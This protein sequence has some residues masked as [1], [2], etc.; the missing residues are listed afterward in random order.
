MVNMFNMGKYNNVRLAHNTYIPTH[1]NIRQPQPRLGL[2][3][4]GGGNHSH[5]HTHCGPQN[6]TIN[7]GPQGFWGF[8]TGLCQGLFGGFFGGGMFGGFGMGNMYGMGM[9]GMYGGSLFN[10]L[11]CLSL[12]NTVSMNGLGDKTIDEIIGKK[13]D[14]TKPKDT[15]E[16]ETETETDKQKQLNEL[17]TKYP[18][19]TIEQ[20]EDGT[21]TVKNSKGETVKTGKYEDLIKPE[22]NTGVDQQDQGQVQQDQGQVQ[23]DQGQVQQD[24]GQVQQEQGQV[25]QDQGQV[26]QDQGQVQQNQGQVQ[27]DQGQVQQNQGQQTKA[28]PVEA[29]K[30]Q[31]GTHNGTFTVHDD[32]NGSRGDIKSSRANFGAINNQGYPTTITVGQYTFKFLEVRNGTAFYQAAHNR[33]EEYRLEQNVDGTFGLNQYKGDRGAG[34][35]TKATPTQ[36]PL[37]T[38]GSSAAQSSRQ[39][40]SPKVWTAAEKAKKVTLDVVLSTNTAYGVGRGDGTATV[41]T[42]DGKT[43]IVNVDVGAGI[44]NDELLQNTLLANL[45]TKLAQEGWTNVVLQNENFDIR[46]DGKAV[47]KAETK[48]AEW[49][50]AEKAKPRSLKISFAVRTRSG[51]DGSATVTT[52]DG[53]IFQVHTGFS[54]N[55]TNARKDLAKK[56]QESLIAAGWTQITL[57]NDT[58]SDWK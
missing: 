53:K 57:T 32:V 36:T 13:A 50:A 6:I 11:N 8:M 33:N 9:P 19:H 18:D 34:P 45:K 25:Q 3:G 38:K 15:T 56:M 12:G 58:W 41:M 28:V 42:P 43:Y 51:N 4:F 22:D 40:G 35:S 16:T 5:C 29:N 31:A 30:I 17:K 20:N 54:L 2:F 49:S 27:Q 26:Q 1:G 7:Q 52:P 44:N 46:T 39:A 55:A 23:Q 37:S 48:K 24:Q 10:N 21:Y 14:T 47:N